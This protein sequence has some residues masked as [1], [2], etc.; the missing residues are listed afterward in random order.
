VEVH[1]ESMVPTLLPGDRLLVDITVYRTHPVVPGDLVVFADPEKPGRWLIKRAAGVGPGQYWRTHSGL[2]TVPSDEATESVTLPAGTV[3][4]AGD[5]PISRDS[6]RFGPIP[7]SLL[8]GRAYYR[9]APVARRGE[10]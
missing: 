10:L 3:Y 6:G 7:L 5:A 1:D 4:V 2:A 8:I 9:Y